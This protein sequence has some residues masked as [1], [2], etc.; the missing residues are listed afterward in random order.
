MIDFVD[1]WNRILAFPRAGQISISLSKS[2]KI[3]HEAK[4]FPFWPKKD[5]F[6]F[7]IKILLIVKLDL[8]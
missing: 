3:S 6:Y 5:G 1:L 2:S 4:A 7:Q 8:L